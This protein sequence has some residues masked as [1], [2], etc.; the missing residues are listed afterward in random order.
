MTIKVCI[1]YKKFDRKKKV[2]GGQQLATAASIRRLWR[3]LLCC[4]SQLIF[5]IQNVLAFRP[6]AFQAF[7]KWHQQKC[8]KWSYVSIL[9]QPATKMQHKAFREHTCQ[10][11]A[12]KLLPNIIF[13]NISVSVT[14]HCHVHIC[15]VYQK[16]NVTSMESP[17][18]CPSITRGQQHQILGIFR[19]L[20]GIMANLAFTDWLAGHKLICITY[21]VMLIL[22]GLCL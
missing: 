17:Q 6:I 22:C 5:L 10:L 18:C 1:S 19:T 16:H 2:T 11:S 15:H 13:H 14:A 9:S 12:K 7:I 8:A 3:T 20:K 21:F 4:R